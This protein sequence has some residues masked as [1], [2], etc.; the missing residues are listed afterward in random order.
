[1]IFMLEFPI[2]D[3]KNARNAPLPTLR[4]SCNRPYRHAEQAAYLH[5]SYS[6]FSAMLHAPHYLL[7]ADEYLKV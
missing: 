5:E 4:S 1:M 2:F 6:S 3:N 7:T